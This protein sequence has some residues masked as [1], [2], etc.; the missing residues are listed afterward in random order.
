MVDFQSRDTRRG[1]GGRDDDDDEEADVAEESTDESDDTAPDAD[2]SGDPT[3]DEQDT[4]DEAGTEQSNETAA[5]ATETEQSDGD[6]E[7]A[8]EQSRETPAEVAGE[9][10]AA[11]ERGADPLVS[12]AED[13]TEPEERPAQQDRAS[14]AGEPAQSG[15]VGSKSAQPQQGASARPQSASVDAAVV[16][17]G[18]AGDERDPT[19][20]KIVAALERAGH[21]VTARERLRGDFDGVQQSVDTLVGRDDVDVVVTAGGTGIRSDEVA[22]EAVHP[23]LEK[24]LPGFGEAFRTLLFEHIGTGIVAVRT[25]A[26]VAKSTPVF[27]LPGDQEAAALGVEEIV[28]AEA[29]ELVAHLRDE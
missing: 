5:D 11:T 4:A 8:A 10:T 2:E 18:T 25:T 26:G 15:P 17:I 22:I 9:A 23:L 28:A 24:A 7:T 20:E 21:A 12:T 27:C 19:G 3:D 6:D 1:L 14:N 13:D 16:T 29:G